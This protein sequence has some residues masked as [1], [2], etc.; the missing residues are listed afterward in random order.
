MIAFAALLVRS[1]PCSTTRLA[2][3]APFHTFSR[4]VVLQAFF[5]LTDHASGRFNK[6][7]SKGAL[8]YDEYQDCM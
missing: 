5:A 1:F 6:Q 8:F 3:N 2:N 4:D 7:E